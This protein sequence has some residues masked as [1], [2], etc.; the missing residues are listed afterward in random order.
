NLT[1]LLRPRDNLACASEASMTVQPIRGAIPGR[2]VRVVLLVAVAVPAA[3]QQHAPSPAGYTAD[4]ADRG[5][6]VYGTYCA[7]C[8]GSDLEGAVGPALAGPVFLRK[9]GAADRD[10]AELFAVIR[11]TMPKPA[12]GSL[13]P[14]AYLDAFAYLL[15]RNGLPAGKIAFDGSSAAL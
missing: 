13:P 3:A 6:K 10:A 7:G 15:E 5:R 14:E 12:V 2:W 4:Q 8:H 9:W 11:T 1:V